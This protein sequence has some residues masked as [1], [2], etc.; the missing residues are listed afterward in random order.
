MKFFGES[1]GRESFTQ[2]RENR[3]LRESFSVFQVF[4]EK[5]WTFPAV[6]QGSLVLAERR[7]TAPTAFNSVDTPSSTP[8]ACFHKAASS[9]LWCISIW[10]GHASHKKPV[11][12]FFA[13]GWCVCKPRHRVCACVY[14]CTCTSETAKLMSSAEEIPGCGWKGWLSP[15][16]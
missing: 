6:T 15:S 13:W 14:A 10:F 3:Q 2:A 9:A 1:G 16:D 4:P 5:N 7:K 12:S 11:E 8:A